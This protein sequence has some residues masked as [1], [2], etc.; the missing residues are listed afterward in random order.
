MKNAIYNK[1]TK[2]TNVAS[3]YNSSCNLILF[4]QI[5]CKIYDTRLST[6]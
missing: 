5:F 1:V 3:S 6:L 2:Y 4:N